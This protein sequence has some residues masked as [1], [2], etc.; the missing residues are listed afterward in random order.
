MGASAQLSTTDLAVEPGRSTNATVTVRNDGSVVDRFSFE[1][2]GSASRYATFSPDT[3]SLFPQAS[4]T[5]TVTFAPPRDPTVAA[6]PTP[7]GVR[8]LSSEDPTESVVE[9]GTLDVGSYS[10][11]QAELMP[12]VTRGRW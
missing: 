11:V 3:L 4:G 12:R 7:F 5:V 1:A 6:G 10:D 8:I 2:V 9:E